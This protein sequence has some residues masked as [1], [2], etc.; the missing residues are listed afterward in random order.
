MCRRL[1]TSAQRENNSCAGDFHT[2]LTGRTINVSA[3]TFIERHC[4]LPW[5]GVLRVAR[6]QADDVDVTDR[7]TVS[8]LLQKIYAKFPALRAHEKSILVGAGVEFVDRSYKLK[9]GE[10]ISIMPPVQGG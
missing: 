10:E 2:L 5:I 3:I 1:R 7:A 6:A 8:D 4:N 9:S